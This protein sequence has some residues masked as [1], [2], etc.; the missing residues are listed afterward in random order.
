MECALNA[1]F[2]I[3]FCKPTSISSTNN[4]SLSASMLLF[5]S[6]PAFTFFL[7]FLP[8]D[9]PFGSPL[10]TDNT[11]SALLWRLVKQKQMQNTKKYALD[12]PPLH[13]VSERHFDA[14]RFSTIHTLKLQGIQK[15]CV[16]LKRSKSME[17]KPHSSE[18]SSRLAACVN[19]AVA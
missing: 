14:G 3:Q 5:L 7:L 9:S 18:S 19:T 2:R 11:L 10:R 13:I 1:N 4:E 12:R 15:R 17:I 16:C 6:S 8:A